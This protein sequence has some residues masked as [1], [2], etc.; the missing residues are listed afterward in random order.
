[1]EPPAKVHPESLADYL[2]VMSKSVFRPGI[3]W[4]VVE[5]KWA[6]IR[7]A[8]VDFDPETIANFSSADFDMLTEDKRIIRNRC[9]IEAIVG[10]AQRMLELDKSH[11]G[12][13][14]YLRSHGSFDELIKD[15]RKQ[16][17]FLGDMGAY[18]FL[19][20]VGEEVPAYEQWSASHGI[21][22]AS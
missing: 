14:N 13:Q 10:N 20:V 2:E 9:K 22:P 17:K 1:M 16:F 3:S 8:F 21:K 15:L 11:N 7:E 12:F 6:G 18:H 5:N 4:R 19:W